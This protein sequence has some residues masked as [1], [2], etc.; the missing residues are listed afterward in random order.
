[1]STTPGQRA[2][3]GPQGPPLSMRWRSWPL[4]EDVPRAVIVVMGLVAAWVVVRWVT[5]QTHL[6]LMAL[7]VLVIALWR[8]YLPVWFELSVEGVNQQ[9]LGRQRR[10][11]WQA[12]HHYE[13]CSAGVLLLP[14]ADRC[15]MDVVRGLFV[16]WGNHHEEVLAQVRYYLGRPKEP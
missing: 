6:A 2:A 1:M 16:P 11:P 10:V 14:P 13:V 7:A 9:V 3:S 12:I 8:F 4:R 15:P 5:G